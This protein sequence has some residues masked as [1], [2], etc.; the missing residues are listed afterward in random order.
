M[1]PAVEK[2]AGKML[3]L[4]DNPRVQRGLDLVA[5]SVG[6]LIDGAAELA[7]KILPDILRLITDD[8]ALKYLSDDAL[9]LMQATDDA[10][11]KYEGLMQSY[12][13]SAGDI[14]DEQARL[15]G[16]WNELQELTDWN[17]RVKASDMERADYILG[18]LND[19]LGTEYKRNGEIIE[20][21]Q[22][23]QT[24]IE[25]LMEKKTAA[26][27]IEMFNE[28]YTQS[29]KDA[30]E[31]LKNAADLRLEMN[32]ALEAWQESVTSLTAANQEEL[33]EAYQAAKQ[34]YEEAQA[35]YGQ[36]Y[37]NIQRYEEAQI[38]FMKGNFKA[39]SA[40]LG[41]ETKAN[42]EFY[43]KKQELNEEDKKKFLAAIEEMEAGIVDDRLGLE[44]GVKGL[45]I[46]GLEKME[47]YVAEARRILNGEAIANSY[48]DGLV[49]GLRAK[50]KLKEVEAAATN[51]AT[52]IVTATRGTLMISSPSKIST[53]FGEMWPAG[54]VKGMK[55][56]EDEVR[57]ESER[58]SSRM[59]GGTATRFSTSAGYYGGAIAAPIG[60]YGSTQSYSTRIGSITVTVPGAG[61]VNEDVLA[62]RV[63]VRLT[64]QL[65]RANS[66]RGG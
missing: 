19:A 1:A 24:E 34:K 12:R 3:E 7:S 28:T 21:Y 35:L 42:I 55:N 41:D 10:K 52:T 5:D 36:A 45:S 57:K 9:A 32:D 61:A 37:G 47:R 43:K 4:A 11:A 20:Q 62:Q 33:E 46:G 56:R 60:G 54:L 22:V 49:R 18:E 51:T 59:I 65:N 48:M 39:V 40:I 50:S 38:E 13:D 16:L 14:L 23:M 44:Q 63:A 64:Q 66:A 30:Q 53:Y 29:Q 58:L 31:L 6:N 26:S 2:A 25:N 17:G 8:P 15:E 27:M